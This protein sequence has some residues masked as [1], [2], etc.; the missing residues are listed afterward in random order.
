MSISSATEKGT[1][2]V[3]T[4]RGLYAPTGLVE[5]I[6]RREEAKKETEARIRVVQK[7]LVQKPSDG[8]GKEE[9]NAAIKWL[10]ENAGSMDE[11][12]KLGAFFPIARLAE[13]G[14]GWVDPL[15]AGLAMSAIAG[16][17]DILNAIS[18]IMQKNLVTRMNSAMEQEIAGGTGKAGYYV[19]LAAALGEPKAARLAMFWE[20]MGMAPGATERLE[21]VHPGMVAEIRAEQKRAAAGAQ[22]AP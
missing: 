10:G 7:C 16:K 1:C 8:K 6:R 21:A 14:C 19:M 3:K 2:S 11:A 20:S 22:N 9:L 12:H 18:G 5:S 17:L 13:E 15:E 4:L